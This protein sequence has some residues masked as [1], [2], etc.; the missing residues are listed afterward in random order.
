MP[1]PPAQPPR[2]P[3]PAAPARTRRPGA[4]RGP[5]GRGGPGRRR[6]AGG[7]GGPH[8]PED[9]VRAAVGEAR[10]DPGELERRLEEALLERAAL[11]VVVPEGRARPQAP[12]R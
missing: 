8:A 5:G 3:P 2:A 9:R 6:G 7:G 4:R 10:R 12:P 11:R 1:L